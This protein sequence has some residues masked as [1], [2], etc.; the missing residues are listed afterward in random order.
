MLVPASTCITTILLLH[1]Y[2][3]YYCC[4]VGDD[5]C[6]IPGDLGDDLRLFVMICF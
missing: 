2:Y 1:Y 3:Y 6:V 4:D 5:L